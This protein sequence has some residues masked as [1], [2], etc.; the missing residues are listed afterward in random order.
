MG[1]PTKMQ[2]AILVVAGILALAIAFLL[3]RLLFSGAVGLFVWAS[4]QGFVGVA[5]YFG[6][7]VFLFPLMLTG[8]ILFGVGS[9][10]NN[11]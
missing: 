11:R 10:W 1:I 7:W 5:V 4:E 6:C 3:L 8:C 9:W 2:T